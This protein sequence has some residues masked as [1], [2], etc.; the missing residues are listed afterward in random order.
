LGDGALWLI[1]TVTGA[2]TLKDAYNLA[3]NIKDY[4]NSS[5]SAEEYYKDIKVI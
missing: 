1:T 5:L 4:Y 3:T 2:G